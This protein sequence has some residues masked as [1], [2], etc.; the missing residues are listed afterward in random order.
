MYPYWQYSPVP[1]YPAVL[2]GYRQPKTFKKRHF[3]SDSE[4]ELSF[5]GDPEY[6]K[7][8]GAIKLTTT[9]IRRWLEKRTI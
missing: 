9:T 2:H 7:K 8:G 6:T 5:P 1:Q 3:Q 4:D